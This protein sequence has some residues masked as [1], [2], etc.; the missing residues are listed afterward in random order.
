MELHLKMA[1]SGPSIGSSNYTYTILKRLEEFGFVRHEL[2]ARGTRHYYAI[3]R[4][5]PR[6]QVHAKT[7]NHMTQ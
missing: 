4:D 7:G 1:K 3:E 2:D 5:D 6:P